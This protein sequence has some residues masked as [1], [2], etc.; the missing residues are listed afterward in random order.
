MLYSPY[1]NFTDGYA[2]YVVGGGNVRSYS[3]NL[4]SGGIIINSPNLNDN[5][6]H[7]YFISCNGDVVYDYVNMD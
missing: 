5:N 2:Y 4:D 7:A 3:M 6:E 1:F